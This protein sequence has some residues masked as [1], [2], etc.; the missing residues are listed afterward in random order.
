[1]AMHLHLSNRDQSAFCQVCMRLGNCVYAEIAYT[2]EFYSCLGENEYH[3]FCSAHMWLITCPVH[4]HGQVFCE[5]SN[6]YKV[7][8]KYSHRRYECLLSGEFH[9]FC[10]DHATNDCQLHQQMYF[11]QENRNKFCC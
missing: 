5:V 6:C 10:Q 4:D 7:A 11:R 3:Y 8:K 9:F 2:R 1:M